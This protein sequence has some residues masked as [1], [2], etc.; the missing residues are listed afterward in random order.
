MKPKHPLFAAFYISSLV[1]AA[2]VVFY[3]QWIPMVTQGFM[4]MMTMWAFG[5]GLTDAGILSAYTIFKIARRG[6][7]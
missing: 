2:I 6:A 7:A 5:Y 4:G 1:T 3:F